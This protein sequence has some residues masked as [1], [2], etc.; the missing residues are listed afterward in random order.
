MF[1]KWQLTKST[2]N[3]DDKNVYGWIRV[4]TWW[5]AFGSPELSNVVSLLSVCGR[6]FVSISVSLSF[7]ILLVMFIVLNV[8]VRFCLCCN[9]RIIIFRLHLSFLICRSLN[10]GLF[11]CV[12]CG[13][14]CM[15][16][17]PHMW[18]TCLNTTYIK[19]ASVFVF[20]PVSL[21][22]SAYCHQV[23]APPPVCGRPHRSENVW[24][25]VCWLW[26]PPHMQKANMQLRLW[27][28][29]Y[30]P[31]ILKRSCG[32]MFTKGNVFF[33]LEGV[34]MYDMAIRFVCFL[35]HS[36]ALSRSHPEES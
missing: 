22:F 5:V 12:K 34:G 21:C 24:A 36:I 20:R 17:F 8:I 2:M 1:Y 4:R 16:R 30:E 7:V 32:K 3:E 15:L 26:E 19:S 29:I 9:C 25:L 28:N 11:C 33:F 35:P 10:G 13:A 27:T 6:S 31:C 14:E 18:K 23:R